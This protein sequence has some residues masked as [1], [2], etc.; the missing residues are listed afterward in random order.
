VLLM[1]DFYHLLHRVL[2]KDKLGQISLS[3]TTLFWGAERPC[4]S[5]AAVG[6]RSSRPAARQVARSSRAIT[7]VGVALGR[8]R[9]RFIP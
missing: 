5:G 2:W 8:C 6:R 4:S 1:R 9:G 3:V 7:A